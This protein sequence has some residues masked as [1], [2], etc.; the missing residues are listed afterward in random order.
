MT[1]VCK[2]TSNNAGRPT[3]R[4][5][6]TATD[7]ALRLDGRR[8]G[9]G[10]GARRLG[11]FSSLLVLGAWLLVYWPA[12]SP[13]ALAQ[14]QSPKAATKR[15]GAA[16]EPTLP[17]AA[18]EMRD[19]IVAAAQTGRLEE[20]RTVLDWN[21]LKPEVASEAVPDAIEHWRSISATGDGRDILAAL[22]AILAAKP[23]ISHQGRDIENSRVFVWPGV[24]ERDFKALGEDD[25]RLLESLATREQIA[26]MIEKSR[27]IGWR[28]VIGADGV[29]HSF[30]KIE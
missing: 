3:L 22:L 16:S 15:P 28:L 9:A 2:V 27:Y 24:A 14:K 7:R 26:E 11:P 21:E 13:A 19:A 6:P 18:A 12:G 25:K 30:K 5:T 1:T 17:H 4:S 10:D 29:W 23:A 8:H 20:L